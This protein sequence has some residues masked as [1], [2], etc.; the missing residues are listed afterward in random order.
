MKKIFLFVLIIFCLS[1][2]GTVKPLND[3]SAFIVSLHC[4]DEDPW[5]EYICTDGQWY[6]ITHYPDGSIQTE[7]IYAPPQD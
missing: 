1:F 5:I 4:S 7:P 2:K 3:N 6:K